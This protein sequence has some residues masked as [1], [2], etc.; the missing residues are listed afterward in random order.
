MDNNKKL[1]VIKL[2]VVC[3][4]DLVI[5]ILNVMEFLDNKKVNYNDVTG[6]TT[7]RTDEDNLKAIDVD[8]SFLVFLARE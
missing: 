5:S 1:E 2:R 8:N 3:N 7:G 6:D 4:K